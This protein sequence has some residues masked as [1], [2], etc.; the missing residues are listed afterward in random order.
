MYIYIYIYI[1][2]SLHH[3]SLKSDRYHLSLSLKKNYFLSISSFPFSEKSDSYHL[4][5]FPIILIL[6]YHFVII[7]INICINYDINCDISINFKIYIKISIHIYNNIILNIRLFLIYFL[8]T[9]TIILAKQSIWVKKFSK[10]IFKSFK[11][12]FG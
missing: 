8:G 9:Y 1:Y 6:S 3:L 7:N 5:P 12:L 10:S 4:S 2:I 11:N